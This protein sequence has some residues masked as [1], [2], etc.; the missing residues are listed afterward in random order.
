[1]HQHIGLGGL[2]LRERELR[3]PRLRTPDEDVGKNLRVLR[4]ER[5]G[6][7][8][9]HLL[10]HGHGDP[11]RH[12]RVHFEKRPRHAQP[13]PARGIGFVLAQPREELCAKA[14]GQLRPHLL[15]GPHAHDPRHFRKRVHGPRHAGAAGEQRLFQ[16]RRHALLLRRCQPRALRSLGELRQFIVRCRAVRGRRCVIVGRGGRRRGVGG[17]KLRWFRRGC[18]RRGEGRFGRGLILGKVGL[19]GLKI[20]R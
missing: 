12:G 9:A 17:R 3:H 20:R 6:V 11:Q 2:Q 8:V 14:R 18:G 15:D 19:H 1:M 4:R 13:H 7:L 16:Q 5:A 10:G